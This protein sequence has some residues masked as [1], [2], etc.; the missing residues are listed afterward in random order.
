MTKQEIIT[1]AIAFY[2]FVSEKEGV[3]VIDII[4]I[5]LSEY[6]AENALA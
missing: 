6:A 5:E 3:N 4:N 1:A 2:I